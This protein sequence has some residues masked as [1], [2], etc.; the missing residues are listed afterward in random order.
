MLILIV[1]IIIGYNDL[2]I[3]NNANCSVTNNT[4]ATFNTIYAVMGTSCQIGL[5]CTTF[6]NGCP[7]YSDNCGTN[8]KVYPFE[9]T[10]D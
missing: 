2:K 3:L 9:N 10:C 1:M 6:F 7:S 8:N 4:A 5:Y